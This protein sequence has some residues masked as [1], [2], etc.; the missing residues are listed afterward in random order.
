MKTR[1]LVLVLA[2]AVAVGATAG[3]GTFTRTA[4]KVN[5]ARIGQSTVD[6]ELEAILGNDAYRQS[7]ESQVGRVQGQ[8]AGTFDAAFAAQVLTRRIFFELV[9]QEVAR[10]RLRIG[11]EELQTARAAAGEQVGGD[12]VLD[13]FP[14]RYRDQLVRNFAEVNAL[15]EALA[16]KADA[17]PDPKAYYDDNPDEFVET[18]A[19]HIL[20]DSQEKAD[21]VRGRLLAGADFAATA[22]TESTDP[23]AAQN[24]GTLPCGRP[25]TYVAEF[26]AAAVRAEIGQVTEPVQSGFG[27]HLILVTA[28]RP[29]PFEEV[30][31]DIEVLLEAR[32]RQ[33]GQQELGDFLQEATAKAKVEIDPRYGTWVEEGPS[34]AHVEPPAVPGPTAPAGAEGPSGPGG[35]TGP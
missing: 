15:Q 3:C 30:K 1:L 35:A 6:D 22:K 33:G 20:L 8:G 10:R 14:R 5:G 28:R 18:C 4:A 13:A 21:E 23:S 16:A 29:L 2:V 25:G 19:G 24:G 7:I 12:K 11:R 32:R 26:E 31:E 9:H 27:W 34:G 17:P